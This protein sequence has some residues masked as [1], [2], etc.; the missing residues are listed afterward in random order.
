MRALLVLLMAITYPVMAD[1][2][3]TVDK[4]GRVIYSDSPANEKA[5]KIELRELNTVPKSETLPAAI[6]IGSSQVQ[7]EKI[8]YKIDIISP[9]SEVTIPPGQRD[10]A[11]AVSLDNPL[12]QNHLLVYFLDGEM[13]EETTK[14]NI[15]VSDVPRG[16][17]TLVVEAIDESGQSL[18]T[19]APVVVNIIRPIIKPA[20]SPKPKA[21]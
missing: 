16:S 15:V 11:I 13:L 17:H 12:R 19:S 18:G 5:E 10:L 14:S 7:E 3:K 20:A 6:S 4:D 8:T 2:Y 21:K 9:S 1:V